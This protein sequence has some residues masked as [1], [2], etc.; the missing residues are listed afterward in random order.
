MSDIPSLMYDWA[1]ARPNKVITKISPSMV[2]RCHRAHYYAIGGV[3]QTTPPS[4]GA[5]LNF[6][7]GF[8]WEKIMAE[9][10]RAGGVPFMEQLYLEDEELGMA[11]TA[12]FVPFV[13]GQ[14][15]VWDSKTESASATKYRKR[16][17]KSFFNSHPEYVHQL[18]AYCLLLRKNG[19]DV[20]QGRFGVITKDN[21]YIEESITPFA[22]TSLDKTEARIKEF[23]AYLDKDE[24]PP[25]DCSG[26]KT[27]YCSYGDPE[28]IE[29]NS[30]GKQVPMKCCSEALNEA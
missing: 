30:T 8:L 25:C 12:D 26:W 24:L 15:E 18:N 21:G 5:I 14:W 29:T 11:G 6:Q 13:N 16:E 1:K 2:G 4:P 28:S 23:K 27:N 17:G 3:A 10:L 7:V 19:F 22:K 20:K 9:A